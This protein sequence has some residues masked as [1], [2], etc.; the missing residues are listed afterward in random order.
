MGW[1]AFT[2]GIKKYFAAFKWKNSQLVDFIGKLQEG[3]DEVVKGDLVLNTWAEK[4]LRTKG[5]NKLTYEYTHEDGLITSFKVRQ[6]FCMFGDEVYR[7][8]S[9]NIGFFHD[10]PENFE[11]TYA[12]L[13]DR[14]LTELP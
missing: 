3:Y 1:D 12:V 9:I 10:G 6:G 11:E 4:W 8:Q 2:T 14:E 7:K 5:P 13:E